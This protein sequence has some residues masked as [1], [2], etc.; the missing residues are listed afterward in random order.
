M[1]HSENLKD[2]RRQIYPVPDGNTYFTAQTRDAVISTS[3]ISSTPHKPAG[4]R[5]G[6]DIQRDIDFSSIK[7]I[8]S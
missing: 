8:S 1:Q 7:S 3:Q 2:D 4:R 6:V 5:F